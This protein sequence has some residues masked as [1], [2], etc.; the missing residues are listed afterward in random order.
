M[1]QK[2]NRKHL[3]VPVDWPVVILDGTGACNARLK[4]ISANGAFVVSDTPLQP[5]KQLIL[6]I[7]P[8]NHRTVRAMFEV[9]R[10]HIDCS[11]NNLSSYGIGMRFTRVSAADLKTL[12]NVTSKTFKAKKA[13][14]SK[15][16]GRAL[17]AYLGLQPRS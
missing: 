3:R 16:R 12:K 11:H 9:V 8:D 13:S 7:I 10:L 5:R 14:L 4:D 2:E 6:F 15:K 17:L 1:A